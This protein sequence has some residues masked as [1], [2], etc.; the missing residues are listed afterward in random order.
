ME[1]KTHIAGNIIVEEIK[2]GDI[3]YEF[4][5]GTYVK[6]KVITSPTINKEGNWEWQ[7]ECLMS[8]N[9]ILYSVNP[10]SRFSH[11]GLK[12]YNYESY[13]GATQIPAMNIIEN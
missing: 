9:K 1:S 4:Q 5:Y 10:D 6:S 7:S 13:F 12:L 2:I 3:H 8:G 11:Y